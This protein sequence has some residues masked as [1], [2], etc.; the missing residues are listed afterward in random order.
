MF[1]LE[2][3]ILHIMFKLSTWTLLWLRNAT[4]VMFCNIGIVGISG[5]GFRFLF[6]KTKFLH[7]VLKYSLMTQK[8]RIKAVSLFTFLL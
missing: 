3:S 2:Y 4:L 7:F 1:M 6:G 5:D 8:S